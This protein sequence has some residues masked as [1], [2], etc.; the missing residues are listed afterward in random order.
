MRE[1]RLKIKKNIGKIHSPVGKFAERAKQG[2]SAHMQVSAEAMILTRLHTH[3][4]K[5]KD[6][7]SRPRTQPKE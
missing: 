5:V 3:Q 6:M 1:A 4:A 2:Q 7:A